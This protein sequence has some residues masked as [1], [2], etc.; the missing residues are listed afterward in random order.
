MGAL[1][2]HIDPL[3]RFTN[4]ENGAVAV[5][6]ALL[7]TVLM[8]F[9]A[10]G[11]DVAWLYKERA[12]LQSIGDLTAV[13]AVATPNDAT[14]RADYVLARNGKTSQALETLETGRFLRNPEIPPQDRFSTL[15]AGSDGINAV[16]L[17][18]QDDAALHFARIFSNKTYVTLDRTSLA[19]RTGAASFSLSSHIL[20]I[21]GTTLN[22]ALTQRFGAAARIG[23]GDMQI[24]A[25]TSVNLGGLLKTLDAQTG[26]PSRNPA[27]ILNATTSGGKLI[28]A[29]QTV[30]PSQV[31][32]ALNGLQAAT[33][34]ASF[35]VASLIG[36]IDTELGLTATDFLAEIDISALDVV[37][38]LVAAKAMGEGITV[39]AE[40]N[41]PGVINA[42]TN[43]IA[44]EPPAHSGLI[45]LG[46]K[47]VQLHRA[48]VRLKSDVK[49][50]PNL[51]GNLGIGISVASVS[52]PLYVEAAGSTA[53]LEQLSCNLPS[54]QSV[55]ATFSTAATAL[56]PANGTSVA[57]LYLG[58][59]PA[60]SGPI[61][62]ADLGFADLLA[63]N[64]VIALPLLPAIRIPGLTIQARSHVAVGASQSETVA[65]TSN[66]IANGQT[67]KTF[68]SGN[69]LSNA[70]N[71]LLSPENTELRVKPGQ[72]GLVS[73]LAAPIVTA[74][75]KLLPERLLTTLTQPVDAVLDATL[76]SIGVE[77][78]AGELTLTH[79]H[80]EPI[81]LVR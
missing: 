9:T 19:T 48:A 13:S 71:G 79:H 23:L 21:D 18:L 26:S 37:R 68:G 49:I 78:G 43:L 50:E 41:V 75:L 45:A 60:G 61:N 7:L 35:D 44:G 27:K 39:D 10:L 81:R 54:P 64:I 77:L 76:A 51:L 69:L 24:L 6:V 63:V 58:T 66:D 80:C 5:I 70:V 42:Q 14:P 34:S 2:L 53:T 3:T 67:T 65:F 31:S 25:G 20:E 4:D 56:H 47:G 8:G 55:A 62:P 11:V 33:G 17:S 32:N 15:P 38:A 1:I 59:V 28:A 46:E 40:I 12:N 52:L 57:A 74:L 72:D 30:L 29:L 16:R 22:N 36:G 73:G